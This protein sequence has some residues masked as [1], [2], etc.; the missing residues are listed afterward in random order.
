MPTL[1]PAAVKD[2]QHEG[3]PHPDLGG[4]PALT[5]TDSFPISSPAVLVLG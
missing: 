5:G 4:P 3:A 1:V 2:E